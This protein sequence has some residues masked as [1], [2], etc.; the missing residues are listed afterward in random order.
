MGN[1]TGIMALVLGGLMY[2][3]PNTDC[4]RSALY[5]Q[6]L[7]S[8]TYNLERYNFV[9]N[10]GLAVGLAG[11]AGL[12]INAFNNTRCKRKGKDE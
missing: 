3:G 7:G 8:I 10:V 6:P 4:G 12:T 5:S 9:E 1:S 2:A 11:L